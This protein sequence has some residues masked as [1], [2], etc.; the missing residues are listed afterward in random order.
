MTENQKNKPQPVNKEA[1]KM[2]WQELGASETAR[3]LGLKIGTVTKWA[4]RYK[5]SNDALPGVAR[6]RVLGKRGDTSLTVADASQDADSGAVA[7][8]VVGVSPS[9]ALKNLHL[10]YSD[11]T[12]T[13]LAQA[14]AAAAVQA[15]SKPPPPVLS[16]SHLRELAAAASRVFGWDSDRGPSTVH[17]TLVITPEQLK[18]IGMLREAAGKETI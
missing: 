15:A 13:A 18:S 17:N 11:K 8:S 7:G 2:L 6:A 3:R 5:W 12:R 10:E 16:T 4:S 1:V 14:T 9:Q